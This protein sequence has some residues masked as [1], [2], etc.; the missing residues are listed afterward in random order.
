MTLNL[1]QSIVRPW[2]Q[3]NQTDV[4]YETEKLRCQNAYREEGENIV[5]VDDESTLRPDQ[6]L[7]N[8]LQCEKER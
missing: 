3:G 8:I 1:R 5:N 6:V 4:A 2:D 7:Y